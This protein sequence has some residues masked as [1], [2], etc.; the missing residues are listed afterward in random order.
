METRHTVCALDCP[1]A[2]AVLV[3]IDDGR[4]TSLRGD[5]DHPVTRGFL[6]AKVTHYLDREYS[7]DRLLYPQKRVGAKGEGHFA[8]IS[9]D[10]ALDTIAEKLSAISREYGSEAILPY[11]YAGTMGLLNGA[12]MDRRFF[13]RLGASRLDRTICSSTGGAALNASLGLRYGTEPEQFRNAKLIIAW[14]ANIHGTN[15]HL[16]PFVVE[17]RRN[18]A[19]LYA[20]DPI[21]TR[22]AGLAD[23]HWAIYPGSDLALALAMMHVIVGEKLY[24]ADYVAK[25]V[26]GFDELVARVRDW[27]PTRAAELTGIP[28]EEIAAL[29]REYAATQPAVIRLNYGVQRSERGGAAV[30]AVLA[31]ATITGSWKHAGGGLQLTTSQAFQFDNKALERPDLQWESPLGREARIVN[32][33]ELGKALTELSDPPVKAMVVYNSNPAGIAPNQNKVL[34]G[35]RREDLFTVVLE[36]AQNDTADH[37]DILLPVTTFLEHTDLYRSY[38]HYYVQLARPALPAPGETRS[39]VEIF[40]T[41]AQRMGFRESCFRDS[42][43]DMI[44]TLL[45][46]GHLFLK[47][48]TLERLD[49]EHSVRLNLSPKNGGGEYAPFLPFA[50]GGFGTPSGK[51]ELGAESLDYTPPVESRFGDRA[52]RRKYPLELIASKADDAMNSTFGYRDRLDRQTSILHLHAEDAAARAIHAGDRVRAFND[53]GSLLLRAEVDES[54]RRGVVRAPAV[55]WAKRA[56]DGRSA[57]ALTSDRLTDIGGG[58]ALFSCLVEVERCGD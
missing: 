52:L 17:A 20:I 5:P 16:W 8:R 56:E 53:R 10:E 48:I 32:M 42:E 18:G 14:G 55:R 21:R 44:R 30:R 35:M 38:G 13:H 37:A 46:S 23:K 43:D 1:D 4:A 15:V 25:F 45:G 40:R 49:R 26:N 29:A 31:L 12:G 19:K 57:N 6:C 28:A 34:T 51:C 41:L 24:D 50:E 33:S 11:S 54:V 47:G 58:P 22:T 9:W 2:C 3:R 36:Q 39:N 27:T 7:P